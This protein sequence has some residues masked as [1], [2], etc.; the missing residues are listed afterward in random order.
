MIRPRK[1][2]YITNLFSPVSLMKQRIKS[3]MM[4]NY[5]LNYNKELRKKEGFLFLRRIY[6]RKTVVRECEG[7]MCDSQGHSDDDLISLLF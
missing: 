1:V 3:E 5:F 7:T 4:I 2:V 6:L